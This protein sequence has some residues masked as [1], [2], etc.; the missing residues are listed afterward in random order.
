ML[1]HSRDNLKNAKVKCL[2]ASIPVTADYC[3]ASSIR[4]VDDS[5]QHLATTTRTSYAGAVRCSLHRAIATHD[6]RVRVH[7]DQAVAQSGRKTSRMP[8]STFRV[9]SSPESCAKLLSLILDLLH[10]RVDT[11]WLTGTPPP[12]FSTQ[13]PSSTFRSSGQPAICLYTSRFRQTL[14]MWPLEISIATKVSANRIFDSCSTCHISM[15]C[16]SNVF[17]S[18]HN[19]GSQ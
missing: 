10:R 11:D 9:C 3:R 19:R 15:L 14:K 2:G 5:W 7:L 8:S 1:S 17:H 18:E 4:Q 16:P 12:C 13:K 6:A